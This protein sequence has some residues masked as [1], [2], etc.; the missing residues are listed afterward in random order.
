MLHARRIERIERR[1]QKTKK[2]DAERSR[3]AGLGI[4]DRKREIDE[5]RLM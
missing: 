5:E 2:K 1:E 3:V 4:R